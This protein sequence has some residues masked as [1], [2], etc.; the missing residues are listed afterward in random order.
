MPSAIS[1]NR[2]A[3]GTFERLSWGEGNG[4]MVQKHD[5]TRL[6]WDLRLELDGHAEELGGDQRGRASIP[7]T[8]RLAVRTEDH[9]LSYATFEGR[10]PR[11][12][13]AAAR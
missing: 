6:H 13:M 3:G 12:N 2:G 4:F 7:P 10:S 8:K 1:E 5:A 11:A 9:P